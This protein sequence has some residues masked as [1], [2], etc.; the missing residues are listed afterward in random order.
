MGMAPA[1]KRRTKLVVIGAIVAVV[2]VA[3]GGFAVLNQS[4]GW[5]P[6]AE[7]SPSGTWYSFT[8]PDNAWSV[9]FPS[10]DT[11]QEMSLSIPLGT[12]QVQMNCYMVRSDGIVYEAGAEDIPGD[13]LSTDPNTNLDSF[14]QGIKVFGTVTDSRDLTFQ[15]FQARE[16]RF[17]YTSL[18]FEG[19]IRFWVSGSRVY[20]MMVVGQPGSTMYPEHFFDTFTAS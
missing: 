4:S 2:L 3:V 19:Y 1:R 17:T 10:S 13:Q 15:G 7:P 14:E 5:T 16:V 11:P 6:A 8:S 12:T 18:S 20:V 9:M